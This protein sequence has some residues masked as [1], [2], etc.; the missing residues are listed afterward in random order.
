M[1]V[2]CETK[3]SLKQ[4]FSEIALKLELITPEQNTN[5]LE[6]LQRTINWLRNTTK[7]W[8]LIYDNA[9]RNNLLTGYWPLSGQGSMLLTSR[10]YFN[11]FEV[12]PPTHGNRR[13]LKPVRM[14][15]EM[16]RLWNV[17]TKP[18]VMSFSWPC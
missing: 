17:S 8:L 9:E 11:F 13:P 16:V 15:P 18:S 6:N 12:S 5:F 4:S 14:K 3:A 1:W 7:K 2:Q 10:S